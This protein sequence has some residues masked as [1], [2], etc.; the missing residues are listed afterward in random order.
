MKAAL[1]TLPLL[2]PLFYLLRVRRRRPFGVVLAAFLA[3]ALVPYIAGKIALFG[4]T[5]PLCGHWLAVM[6]LG[7]L[8]VFAAS[9]LLCI[10]ELVRGPAPTST[11]QDQSHGSEASVP[12][13]NL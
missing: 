6:L 11:A 9:A 1:F 4:N 3:V 2:V 8:Y 5:D 12:V 13:A 7:P 10:E